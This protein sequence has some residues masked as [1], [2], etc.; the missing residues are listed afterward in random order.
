MLSGMLLHVVATACGVNLA[1][2]AGS[3]LH[4]LHRRFEVVDDHAVFG[5]GDFG[6]AQLGWVVRIASKDPSRVED[7]SAAG[8]IKGGAV[9]NQCWAWTF[10][11]LPNF[12]VEVVEEG[13]V[14]VEAVGHAG[15]YLTTEDTE[16]HGGRILEAVPTEQ[17]TAPTVYRD[18][19]VRDALISCE[20][21]PSRSG[22]C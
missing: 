17:D 7:L 18:V 20:K 4:I 22:F 10:R 5:V 15:F 2:D 9:E 8:G 13:I 19:L 6:D 11:R 14:V 16:E 3:G 21:L 1:T 12:G